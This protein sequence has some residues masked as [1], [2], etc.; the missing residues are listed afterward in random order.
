MRRLTASDLLDL[1]AYEKVREERRARIIESKRPRRI[2]VGPELTFIFEN[3]DTVWFQ[4][5]EMMRTERL[6][7]DERIQEE[8]DVYN[9]LLPHDHGLS[10]TLM[11][12]IT[13]SGQIRETLDRLIGIDE[14]VFLD[15]GDASVQATFDP[16]QFE[17]DRISAVQ[18][19]R[20]PLG[21][22]LAARFRDPAT[23]VALRVEHPHYRH[24]TAVSGPARTAL[25]R[26]L[27]P[28]TT[29]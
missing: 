29:H 13:A 16:K 26:D 1:V 3:R 25:A 10:A 19:V 2:T 15:V 8:L 18:Y 12:E 27:E 20:F 6:V 23:A 11:I 5:Q 14:Q 24:R 28:E 21:A 22:E 4:V 17:Q 9:E 7:Q